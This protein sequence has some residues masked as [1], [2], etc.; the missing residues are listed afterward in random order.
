MSSSVGRVLDLQ[1]EVQGY[2]FYSH[3]SDTFVPRV[4]ASIEAA[5]RVKW[6]GEWEKDFPKEPWEPCDCGAAPVPCKLDG[7]HLMDDATWCPVCRTIVDAYNPSADNWD[8]Y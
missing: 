4:C 2:F 8:D 3:T 5:W 6:P 1:G 7:N